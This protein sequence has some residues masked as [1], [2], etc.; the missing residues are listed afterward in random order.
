MLET[1]GE[2][3]NTYEMADVSR[4]T[5][6]EK[7]LFGKRSPA[8]QRSVAADRYEKIISSPP[9]KGTHMQAL[10][11]PGNIPATPRPIT[12][13]S[14]GILR[15]APPASAISRQPPASKPYSRRHG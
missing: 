7:H 10:L 5:S 1:G 2:S 6:A 14:V 9:A 15:A 8:G 12:K 11:L 3:G 4:E 13:P